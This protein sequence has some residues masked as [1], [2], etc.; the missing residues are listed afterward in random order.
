MKS[1]AVTWGLGNNIRP[2]GFSADLSKL[3]RKF[4][5]LMYAISTLLF[6][7]AEKASRV[8]K[9]TYYISSI[10]EQLLKL[11]AVSQVMQRRRPKVGTSD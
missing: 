4:L 5:Q 7:V 10:V 9:L 3:Y 8:H 11:F 2:S 6:L 1:Q